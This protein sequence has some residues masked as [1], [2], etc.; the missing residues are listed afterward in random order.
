M[1]TAVLTSMAL[2]LLCA[3]T[4]AAA[5]ISGKWSSQLP[6]GHGLTPINLTFKVEGANLTG[7]VT[8]VMG[9]EGSRAEITEGK[10]GG[11]DVSFRAVMKFRDTEM[12]SIYQGKVAGNEIRFTVQMQGGPIGDTPVEVEITAKRPGS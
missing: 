8:Y 2:L 11:D 5:D 3:F 6:V 10:V 12:K 1:R 7:T 4:V 9:E